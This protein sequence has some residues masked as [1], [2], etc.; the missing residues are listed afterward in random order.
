MYSR[1][2]IEL[3]LNHKQPDRT[4]R[5]EYVLFS[6]VADRIIGSK[7]YDY[8]CDEAAWLEYAADVGWENAL[9]KYVR[10][11]LD[12]VAALGHDMLYVV[13]N[14]LPSAVKGN[15][16]QIAGE[17]KENSAYM[18]DDPEERIKKKNYEREEALSELI[19]DSNFEVYI[20]LQEE[21]K[22][23][24]VDLPVLAPAYWH[25][26]WT[27]VDLMETMLIEPETAEWHFKLATKEAAAYVG[28]YLSLGIKMIGVGGDFAGNR[29]LISPES[30]RKFIMPEIR[31]LSKMIHEAGGWAINTSDGNLWPVIEDFLIGC[32]VDGY[33][34][35]DMRAG[36][37]LAKLK[38]EYGASITFLGNM[39]CGEILSFNTPEQIRKY[40]IK[41]LE[42]GMGDGGHIFCASN[43]ITDSVPLCN[44]IAMVNAYNE[45][46]G[47]SEI[48]WR[49]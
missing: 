5:F 29:L 21:M 33:L 3:A 42:D 11:R 24:G 46:F 1:E 32:N 41:C 6:S 27:N 43:A 14:P 45:F 38:K 35:I 16:K 26:I 25:G 17:K 12:I 23:R 4:P 34:E 22:R 13:P 20:Y 37:D 48:I 47:L 7:Y 44:Y 15:M 40:T 30:Y 10:D 8:S 18:P 9:R 39:D 19:K 36:M 49:N 2:R 31:I 28:K